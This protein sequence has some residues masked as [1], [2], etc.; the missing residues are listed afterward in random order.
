MDFYIEIAKC[1][2][3][4]EKVEKTDCVL[5]VCVLFIG[6]DLTTFFLEMKLNNEFAGEIGSLKEAEIYHKASSSGRREIHL[7]HHMRGNQ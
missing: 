4:L 1:I 7:N 5:P 6:I 2:F 3:L